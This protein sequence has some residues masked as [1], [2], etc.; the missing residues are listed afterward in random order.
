MI[1][2]CLWKL[3]CSYNHEVEWVELRLN[4]ER[5]EITWWYFSNQLFITFFK[6]PITPLAFHRSSFL[7]VLLVLS[8]LHPY[9]SYYVFKLYIW[10]GLVVTNVS[11][12]C[13]WRGLVDVIWNGE[14]KMTNKTS[15]VITYLWQ[16]MLW[17]NNK[18]DVCAWCS[19]F[20]C[21]QM[22]MLPWRW[23]HLQPVFYGTAL[24]CSNIGFSLASA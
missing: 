17:F 19:S 5:D 2:A 12:L 14:C 13:L 15:K 7:N 21:L 16:S 9:T 24:L 6:C 20:L 11:L 22:E 8:L 23:S 10:N 4:Q 1:S 3:P 18:Q